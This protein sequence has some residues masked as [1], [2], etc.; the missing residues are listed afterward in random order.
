MR[1]C[2]CW[3]LLFFVASAVGLPLATGDWRSGFWAFLVAPVLTWAANFS[4]TDLRARRRFRRYFELAD[5]IGARD[6]QVIREST[7][8]YVVIVFRP[9][10]TVQTLRPGT[11]AG[12]LEKL[13]GAAV[14]AGYGLV[15]RG[16]F[17]LASE[18]C[19]VWITIY[20]Y[21]PGQG[22]HQVPEGYVMTAVSVDEWK[23]SRPRKPRRA[24]PA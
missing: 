5:R 9:G 15:P 22:R 19:R 4:V 20:A 1:G 7:R 14:E 8:K 2:R 17:A 13:R 12:V 3:L 10:V 11:E 18:S 16:G 24:R 6:G 21:G 23:G